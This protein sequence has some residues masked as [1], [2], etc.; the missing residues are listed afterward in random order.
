MEQGKRFIGIFI[1]CTI[2]VMAAGCGKGFDASGYTEAILALQFQGDVRNAGAFVEGTDR[3]ELMEMYQRFVDD[4]VAGYITNG[5][6]VSEAQQE[7]FSELAST[8]FT[9]M[10]YEVGE[11]KKAGKGEYEV[12][13]IIR[14]SD[15]FIR[16]RDLLTEDSVK[17]SEKVRKGEYGGDEE[18]AMEQMMAEIAVNAY[19]LL[20]TAYEG[21]EYGEEQTVI[22][23]VATDGNEIYSI[24]AEDMD[25]LI[26]KILRLDEIGG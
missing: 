21:S 4:F 5:M 1:V 17:M 23:R 14:P 6:T 9:S 10:R 15:T 13:V 25:N 26:A 22:L 18:E 12:P 2:C 11:A 24:D 20:E 7:E 16:Y 8:I 19:E 3:A